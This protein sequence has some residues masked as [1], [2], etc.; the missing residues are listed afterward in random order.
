MFDT[1]FW[2]TMYGSR[3]A[4]QH[5]K[6]RGEPGAIIN[7][8]SL[9]GDYPTPVQSTYAARPDGAASTTPAEAR[10]AF[11]RLWGPFSFVARLRCR[12]LS[13]HN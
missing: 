1:N 9:F 6:Q 4:V 5:Y 2:G 11:G 7:V 13:S 3:L 12:V 8:G 10:P